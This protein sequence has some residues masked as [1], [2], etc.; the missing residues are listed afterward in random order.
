MCK[1]KVVTFTC[2]NKAMH[3][4]ILCQAAGYANMATSSFRNFISLL[5]YTSVLILFCNIF[6]KKKK[7]K[8]HY[9]QRIQQQHGIEG[10]SRNIKRKEKCLGHTS[11]RSI[12]SNEV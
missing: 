11:L 3:K 7:K 5:C 2:R 6:K 12:Q 1:L 9:D 4:R 8:E 10:C